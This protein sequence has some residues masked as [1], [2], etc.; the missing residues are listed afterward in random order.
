MQVREL[1]ELELSELKAKVF[2]L[3]KSDVFYNDLMESW[4]DDIQKEYEKA[5]YP[6]DISNETIYTLFEHYSFVKEDFW[7][8]F[9]DDELPKEEIFD[10]NYNVFVYNDEDGEDL[11]YTFEYTRLEDAIAKADKC[12][13]TYGRVEILDMF[14][15]KVY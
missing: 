8:N 3:N 7:C 11:L 13:K 9:P 1:N 2:Y 12:V 15:E 14:G 6:A 5:N 4:N 10:Y